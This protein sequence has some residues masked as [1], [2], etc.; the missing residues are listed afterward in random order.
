MED[1]RVARRASPDEPPFLIRSCAERQ[2]AETLPSI[3]VDPDSVQWLALRINDP[4]AQRGSGFQAERKRRVF[5]PHGEFLAL[6]SEPLA[7][8]GDGRWSKRTILQNEL[9]LGLGLGLRVVRVSPDP[10]QTDID[11]LDWLALRS[12]DP[13]ADHNPLF[14]AQ[15]VLLFFQGRSRFRPARSEIGMMSGEVYP[16][17]VSSR[18][19]IANGPS[20]GCQGPQIK[21]QAAAIGRTGR[22]HRQLDCCIGDRAAG[23]ILNL[24]PN[25]NPL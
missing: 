1:N 24:S 18:H 8:D 12:E 14:K 21:V 15:N 19:R 10:S 23:R 16:G 17:Q 11:F 3:S 9:P 13:P 7:L 6:R 25:R 4:A 22:G 20:I 2:G 5:F